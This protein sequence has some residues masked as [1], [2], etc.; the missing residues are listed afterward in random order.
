MTFKIDELNEKSIKKG[1]HNG[2][3]PE[4]LQN[5]PP[6]WFP[7]QNQQRHRHPLLGMREDVAKWTCLACMGILME[8]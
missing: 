1:I 3:P 6:W 2:P 4:I 5:P 7:P 8:R